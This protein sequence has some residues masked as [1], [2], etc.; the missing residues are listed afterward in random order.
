MPHS[1]SSCGGG[2]TGLASQ[3]RTLRTSVCPGSTPSAPFSEHHPE[4]VTGTPPLLSV[5]YKAAMWVSSDRPQRADSQAQRALGTCFLVNE[6]YFLAW[7]QVSWSNSLHTIS[8]PTL[9]S[10]CPCATCSLR[11][12]VSGRSSCGWLPLQ[13]PVPSSPYLPSS[14]IP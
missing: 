7:Y 12:L 6:V 4:I 1:P 10:P 5:L 14:Q 13:G 11:V 3:S 8:H 2:T 9:K